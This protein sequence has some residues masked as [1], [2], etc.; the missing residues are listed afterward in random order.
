M[1]EATSI[2]RYEELESKFRGL[3]IDTSK[4]GFYDDPAFLEAETGNNGDL[5]GCYAEYVAVRPYDPSYLAQAKQ[6]A[7]DLCLFLYD[8]LL[9]DAKAASLD[10]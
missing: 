9:A 2:G 8:K 4:P 5:L 1:S 7:K 3:E 6:V 10:K